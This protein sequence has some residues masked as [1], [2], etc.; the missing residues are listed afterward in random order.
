MGRRPVVTAV[1]GHRPW[2]L[3]HYL[4]AATAVRLADEGAR[5]SL[6]LLAL[7]RTGSA[8][9][10]GLL[11]A[12]LLVPHVLAAPVVGSALGRAG[13]P[14]RL[15][16]WAVGGFAAGLLAVVLLVGRGPLWLTV[17]VLVAAGCC[18]PAVTGGLTS[19]LPGL[20]GEDRAPRA[21]GLDSLFY[22]VSGMAGPA[23]VA[24]VAAVAGPATAQVALGAAAA[25]G[26]LGVASLPVAAGTGSPPTSASW[27]AGLR[28]VAGN[29]TLRTVTATSSLGQVGPGGLGVVAAVLATAAHRPAAGGWMVA[30]AAGG[31][32]VGSLLWTARPAEVRRAPLV[33]TVSMLGIGLPLAA[34]AFVRPLGAVAA[35]FAVS[36]VFVGPFAAALFTTRSAWSSDAARTQ[37]FTIGAGLKVTAA[38]AGAL[39]FGWTSH[40]A[41]PV[42][43]LLVAASPLLAGV[44]GTLLLR[45]RPRADPP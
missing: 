10:G 27:T 19:T 32:L 23:A 15:L 24:V 31:S 28:E 39:L 8:A 18:G 36:G 9:T 5:I 41:V 17:V 12:A 1:R 37:V 35:L 13:R 29:P 42:Q 40:L 22:N 44:L 34:A 43:L 38:A 45:S 3:T 33:V 11:V 20:V 14:Q 25:L 2:V 4:A 21:F 26:A 6:V 7:D 16:A 30:A